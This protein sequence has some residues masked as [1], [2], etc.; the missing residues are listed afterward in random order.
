MVYLIS[1]DLRRPGQSYTSL[2]DS[3][4]KMGQ[5]TKPLESVWLVD[6]NLHAQSI[7]ERLMPHIDQ[8]DSL[9]VAELGRDRQGWLSRDVWNWL[10][11]RAAA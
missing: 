7:S 4:K 10:N 5:W 3:I 8:N 6:T 11:G 1:Y 2:Y 9:L